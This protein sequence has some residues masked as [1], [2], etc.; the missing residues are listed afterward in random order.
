MR[1]VSVETILFT[2]P[3]AVRVFE[4][5][6]D[7]IAACRGISFSNVVARAYG[8]PYFIGA[9]ERPFEGF[10]FTDCRFVRDPSAAGP[11][12]G[13]DSAPPQEFVL[14]NCRGFTFD[15]TKFDD[16]TQNHLQGA[17]R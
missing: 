17:E 8:F 13:A 4:G 1:P 2:S 15:R 10:A 5:A 14:R 6:E 16:C 12:R 9:K 7:D 11:W 3:L